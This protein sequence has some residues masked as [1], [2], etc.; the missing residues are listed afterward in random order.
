VKIFD[1]SEIQRGMIFH[2]QDRDRG[3]VF[4]G[5]VRFYGLD[6]IQFDVLPTKEQPSCKTLG[7]YTFNVGSKFTLHGVKWND[8]QYEYVYD[9][10]IISSEHLEKYVE[11]TKGDCNM[12]LDS[13]KDCVIKDDVRVVDQ[14]KNGDTIYR[15][16]N[17]KFDIKAKITIADIGYRVMNI[18]LEDKD[19][20]MYG[21]IAIDETMRVFKTD[22]QDDPGILVQ[23]QKYKFNPELRVGKL[24][25]MI[26][27]N[28]KIQY[29]IHVKSMTDTSMDV[30]IVDI[31]E[32]R[33]NERSVKTTGAL[34]D[35]KD[36]LEYKFR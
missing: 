5:R 35:I 18:H 16:K 27:I 3:F 4:I 7:M 36:L 1:F 20:N 19:I 24:Y 30:D 28:S 14:I 2:I 26:N 6:F 21:G 13:W 22:S 9:E 25:I 17:D 31:I 29:V 23:H 12:K 8:E 32:D 33:Y 34:Y 11:D 10:S 15:L